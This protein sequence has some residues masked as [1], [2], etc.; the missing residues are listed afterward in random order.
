GQADSVKGTATGLETTRTGLQTAAQ[1]L[2]QIQKNLT[3]N[4]EGRLVW[5]ELMKAL[6]AALP[7]DERPREDTA[8][9][10]ESRNELHIKSMDVQEFADLNGEYVTATDDAYWAS[11]G[12]RP[13]EGADGAATEES[14]AVEEAPVE[15]PT[16]GDSDAAATP[17]GYVVQL[18]GH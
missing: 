1:G 2:I 18:T 7:K 16:E 15:A 9:H 5:L 3:S 8:E 17:K 11:K 12:G 10:V 6:D 4:V 14:G 13:G